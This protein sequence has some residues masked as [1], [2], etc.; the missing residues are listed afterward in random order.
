M[1]PSHVY[2]PCTLTGSFHACLLRTTVT[3]NL[4]TL[5]MMCI[6]PVP[7]AYRTMFT[8]PNV[9]IMNIMACRVFRNIRFGNF[10]ENTMQSIIATAG[11]H[12]NGYQ[13]SPR[14]STF[15]VF[16]KSHRGGRRDLIDSTGNIAINLN[17]NIHVE[18]TITMERLQDSFKRDDVNVAL[19]QN[20]PNE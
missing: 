5:I 19:D 20:H 4:V 8:G 2:S 9:L 17:T 15:G 16:D 3:S 18:K 10:A 6:K 7:E 11:D 14:S 1:H 13:L 12:R